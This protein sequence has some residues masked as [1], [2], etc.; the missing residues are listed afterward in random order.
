MVDS[1]LICLYIYISMRLRLG[2]CLVSL[3]PKKTNKKKTTKKLRS[4][5][6]HA[7]DFLGI[8][9]GFFCLMKVHKPYP[10]IPNPSATAASPRGC[11]GKC[12]KLRPIRVAI[13]RKTTSSPR[14]TFPRFLPRL[15][16]QN[17]LGFKNDN[18]TRNAGI[19][20]GEADLMID[21]Y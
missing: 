14:C 5:H 3:I 13:P 16:A 8:L 7:E 4:Y 1:T 21:K 11:A 15:R 9:F 6:Q 19:F 18:L 17:S 10:K 12:L 2:Y 20:E